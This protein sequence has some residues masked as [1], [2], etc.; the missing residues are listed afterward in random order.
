MR[1]T[2]RPPAYA[3]PALLTQGFRPFFLAGAIWAGL[4]AVVWLAVLLGRLRVPTALAPAAW[5]AHEMLYGYAAAVIVGY[6]FTIVPNW[7]GQMPLQ[8]GAL[9]ALV[10]TWLGGRLAVVCSALIG[11]VPAAVAD[12]AFLL[13]ALAIMTRELLAGRNARS[14]APVAILAVLAAGNLVFHIAVWRGQ[15][16][17]L[18]QRI[19]LAAAIGLVSLVGGRLIPSF[20]RNWLG[21]H[22]PGG[23]LPAP[24]DRFDAATLASTA[25]ALVLWTALPD[26]PPTSAALLLAGVLHA[27]RLARWAGHRTLPEAL[28]W[29]LHAGYGFVA[30]GFVL[31]AG[32]GWPMRAIAPDA[33]IHAWTMG[34]I[35]TLTLAI[36]SRACLSYTGRRPEADAAAR[37]IVGAVLLATL[38]RI[39]ATFGGEGAALLLPLATAAWATAFLGFALRYGPLLC[40]RRAAPHRDRVA[41]D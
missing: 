10:A 28:V 4:A 13:A 20:T 11:A 39:G 30:A 16:T 6:L 26:A 36:M 35:G 1:R 15:S 23:R 2:H 38:A 27:L 22:R 17:A 8:G 24:A 3:G 25:M 31:L 29:A 19:G 7:S 41:P 37:P 9:A 40:R 34:A 5:H 33:G 32:A 18:G 14:A 12:A 21:R